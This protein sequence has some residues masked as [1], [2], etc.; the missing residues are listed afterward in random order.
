M[1]S[2]YLGDIFVC[3]AAA[4]RYDPKDPYKETLLY[5]VHG[6]LHLLGYDDIEPAAKRK[7]RKMERKCMDHLKQLRLIITP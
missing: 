2:S 3:P 6:V 1:D 5:L 7:M 4:L